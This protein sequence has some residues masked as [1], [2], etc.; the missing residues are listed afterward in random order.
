MSN[1]EKPEPTKEEKAFYA[2]HEL[3][4]RYPSRNDVVNLYREYQQFINNRD[5]RP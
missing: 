2:G 3:A 1:R 4:K 5:K